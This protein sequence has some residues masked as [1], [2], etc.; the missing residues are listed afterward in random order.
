MKAAGKKELKRV[1]G[2]DKEIEC[3]NAKIVFGDNIDMLWT[4]NLPH[5]ILFAYSF[6][7]LFSIFLYRPVINDDRGWSLFAK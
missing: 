1:E 2:E 4:I 3:G 5:N 6:S 7:F